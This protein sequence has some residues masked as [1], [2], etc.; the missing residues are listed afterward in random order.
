MPIV[1]KID[2]RAYLTD[3][4]FYGDGRRARSGFFLVPLDNR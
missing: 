4:R 2:G 1:V 3:Q